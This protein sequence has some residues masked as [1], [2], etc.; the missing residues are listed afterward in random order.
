MTPDWP[1][2]VAEG[3]RAALGEGWPGAEVAV[4][5]GSGL[6]DGA[7]GLGVE[8]RARYG[9]VPGLGP[10]AVA[11]HPGE[12]RRGRLGETQTVAFCGRRHFYEG[13]SMAEAGYPARLA[14]RLGARLLVVLSAVGGVD[15]ALPV[16]AWVLVDDHL[17]LMGR[18][19]L[20]G[21]AT[22]AGPAFV[23]L[24]AT[25]RADLYPALRETLAGRGV[26]LHRGV[27]A[28][29]PGPTYETPA[30]VRM[31]RGLGA[32]LVGMSTVPEAV[33]AR[34]LG[35]EV[36]AFG[37]VANPAAGV[38]PGPL[39]HAEVVRQSSRGGAEARILVETAVAVWRA[40]REGKRTGV[41]HS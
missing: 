9:D 25:Y 16:G 36:L 14:A 20:E 29:F 24:T 19:P 3:A 17:N 4:L 11:G 21:I 38:A 35:L 23:D 7:G 22:P 15:P 32:S 26:A 1:D 39:D 12:L 2:P 8:R 34:F 28:A 41:D 40:D 5:L 10:C 30:E 31:A 13:L 27:L 37:R 18:N 6:A 33:W